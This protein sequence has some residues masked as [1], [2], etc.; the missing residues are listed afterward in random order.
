MLRVICRFLSGFVAVLIFHV[1]LAH[2]AAAK[3]PAWQ[4]NFEAA[5]AKAKA[6]KK[7]LLVAFI[8]SD[9]CPWCKKIKAEVFEKQAFA[10]EARKKYVLVEVDFPHKKKLSDELKEQNGKLAKRYKIGAYPSVLLLKPDGELIAHT[11]YSDGGAKDYVKQLADL[12]KTY[13]SLAGLR[14]TAHGHG[15]RS[16][17]TF[18][19]TD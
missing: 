14:A 9:W 2:A 3:E 15:A 1:G 6:Q 19:P 10:S 17:E 4:T 8:G 5:Q 7:I 18:G 12:M 11:G 13:R 16:G